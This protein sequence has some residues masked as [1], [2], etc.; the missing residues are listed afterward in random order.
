MNRT[1]KYTLGLL[2]L[3]TIVLFYY[4]NTHP[5]QIDIQKGVTNINKKTHHS[6]ER[7]HQSNIIT[8]SPHK[9][10]YNHDENIEQILSPK[11]FTEAEIEC[12]K[13]SYHI[14]FDKVMKL[15]EQYSKVKI[16]S[17][18][19]HLEVNEY[20][21]KGIDIKNEMLQSI[22]AEIGK[23]KA[24]IFSGELF[25][26]INADM[27]YFGLYSKMFDIKKVKRGDLVYSPVAKDYQVIKSYFTDDGTIPD[28]R[29]SE[30][31][32]F[33]TIS[34]SEIQTSIWRNIINVDEIQE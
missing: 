14:A 13:I 29:I 11:G 1:I 18:T 31:H 8:Y 10:H 32:E 23:E 17:N 22:A 19:I 4:S 15:E 7:A 16:T 33:V 5:A 9:K 34:R 2:V 25:Q 6:S 21:Q 26:Q 20:K 24:D 3:I 28:S 12:I 27:G 30:L